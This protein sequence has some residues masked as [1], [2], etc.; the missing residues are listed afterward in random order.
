[1]VQVDRTVA[2]DFPRTHGHRR[3][4]LVADRVRTLIRALGPI[5]NLADLALSY[6]DGAERILHRAQL[7]FFGCRRGGHR[8]CVAPLRPRQLAAPVSPW[9][10]SLTLNFS[11]R[12]PQS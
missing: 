1:M 7:R 4:H 12:S 2:S 10:A 5:A 6:R 9:R 8:V 11:R 3:R